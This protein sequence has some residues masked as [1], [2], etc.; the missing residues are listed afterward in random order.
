MLLRIILSKDDNRRVTIN[1][2][3]DV[4]DFHA[5]LKTKLEINGDIVVQY[6]DPEF[7]NELCNLT[8]MS[9]LPKDRAT[10]KVYPKAWES[11]H[12]DSTLDTASM[13]SSSLEEGPSASQSC[14]LPQPFIIPAFL[15]WS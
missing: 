12:T 14:Q 13:S 10:L 1:N 15:M 9:E 8:S 6:K 4:V 5:I 7:D 3:P 11:N 2:L